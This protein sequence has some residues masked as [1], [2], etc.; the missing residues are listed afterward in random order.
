MENKTSKNTA[1]I[2]AGAALSISGC[3]MQ[4]NLRNALASPLHLVFQMQQPLVLT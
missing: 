2:V 3:I 4:N 1:A